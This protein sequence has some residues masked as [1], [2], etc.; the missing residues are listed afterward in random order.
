[1]RAWILFA[2]TRRWGA[3]GV[4]AAGSA[5]LILVCGPVAYAVNP[6]G[7]YLVAVAAQ[8]PL[9]CAVTIQASLSPKRLVQERGSARELGRWRA[10]HVVLFTALAAIALGIAGTQIVVP[11][12]VMANGFSDLGSVALIRNLFA[13]TGA[14]LICAA[15]AGPSF[16]WILPF[17]WTILPFVFFSSPAGDPTGILTLIMQPDR[18]V[19]P[20]SAALAVWGAGF[21][22]AVRRA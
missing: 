21:A 17:A 13:L 2:R 8:V 16:G 19:V 7:G 20:W 14:A 10:V 3:N 11:L 6:V 18:S 4:A 12:G 1:M 5:G 9:I 15:M 22:V